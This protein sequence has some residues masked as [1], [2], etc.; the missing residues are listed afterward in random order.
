MIYLRDKGLASSILYVDEYN[1]A[2]ISTNFFTG[3]RI[4]GPQWV[5]EKHGFDSLPLYVREKSVLVL[6]RDDT[7]DYDYQS[8]TD[9]RGYALEKGESASI[10]VYSNLNDKG[11]TVTV[12]G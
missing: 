11:K 10:I 8:A 7:F 6:G 5:K 2:G 12:T 9:I 1:T 4:V 3:A